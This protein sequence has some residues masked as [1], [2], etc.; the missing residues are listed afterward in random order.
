M[1]L[2]CD[3]SDVEVPIS[4]APKNVKQ[5]KAKKEGHEEEK[6]EPGS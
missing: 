3:D 6:D 1:I 5:A 2:K 4:G